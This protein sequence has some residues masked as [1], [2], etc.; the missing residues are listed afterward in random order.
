MRMRMQ[1][2]EGCCCAPR[3]WT[4]KG[5]M[6]HERETPTA[7]AALPWQKASKFCDKILKST[8]ENVMP[9]ALK[10]RRVTATCM[11]QEAVVRRNEKR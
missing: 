7:A 2:D 9:A 8:R 5:G 10:S 1:S 6:S 4:D 3:A 11:G